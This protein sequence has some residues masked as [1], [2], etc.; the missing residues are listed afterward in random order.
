MP[1]ILTTF[2]L[3]LVPCFIVSFYAPFIYSS[4]ISLLIFLLAAVTDFMDGFLARRW[5]KTTNFGEFLD[6]LV[7]KV[8]VAVALVLVCEYFHVYWVT[9]PS[10]IIISREIVISALRQLIFSIKGNINVSKTLWI[11][12]TKTAM[13]MFSLTALIWHPNDIVINIGIIALYIA[14]ILTL[15][16]MILYIRIFQ[17]NL[18]RNNYFQ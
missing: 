7:D 15:W 14:V 10:I 4:I 6:P 8:M 17:C 1:N 3:F 2:R 5:N 9:I 18:S 12:K 13:Q 11:S 16:S